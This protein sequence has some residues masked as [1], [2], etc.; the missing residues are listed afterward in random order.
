MSDWLEPLSDALDQAT[1][2]VTFFFRDDDVGWEHERLYRLLDLFKSYEI[3]IDLAMIPEALSPRLV[4]ELRRRIQRG[5]ERV[6]LHQHGLGH[7]NHEPSGRKCEF[8]ASRSLEQQDEDLKLGKHLLESLF[9]GLID[10]IFTPP[11]NRCTQITVECLA[12]QSF[13][14]LSRDLGAAPL[15][16]NGMSE[17][18]V[19]LDWARYWRDPKTG[20]QELGR[21][22][23]A[24]A[25][26]AGPV[27]VMLHHGMME[28]EQELVHLGQLLDLLSTHRN[29]H[30]AL[31][32]DIAVNLK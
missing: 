15:E 26:N 19:A 28:A 11:W 22:I 10:P 5:R 27:G 21:L 30:C 4:A 31:M 8:G 7:V 3:P 14:V 32:R 1:H 29:A 13:R 25:M 20:N 12:V 6:G 17:L 23:S 2:P 9:G 18:P 24:Q 16:L